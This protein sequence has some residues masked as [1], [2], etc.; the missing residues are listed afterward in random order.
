MGPRA[1]AC[2]QDTW[3]EHSPPLV[4]VLRTLANGFPILD[5]FPH[6][7]NGAKSSLA[8]KEKACHVKC[9]L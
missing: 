5:L 1:Q 6:M 2:D 8:A 3:K 4:Q 9:L 7:L